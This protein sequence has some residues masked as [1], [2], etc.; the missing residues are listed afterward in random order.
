MT[1]IEV[2]DV[3]ER[4]R[5][6]ARLDG[7]VAGFIDYR[8]AGSERTFRH[9]EVAE[10]FGGRGVGG[11]LVRAAL[12]DLRARGLRLRPVCPFVAEWLGRHPDY[13]DLLAKE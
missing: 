6:E 13:Q 10:E 3:P 8:A 1:A 9:T 5:Y 2:R 12:D 7:T 4:H 11:G